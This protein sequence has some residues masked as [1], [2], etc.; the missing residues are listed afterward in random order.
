MDEK[1]FGLMKII[2]FSLPWVMGA[3]S[4]LPCSLVPHLGDYPRFGTSKHGRPE[5]AAI[6]LYEDRF[7]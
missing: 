2:A 3:L 7:S 4:A 6:I 1:M 5:R